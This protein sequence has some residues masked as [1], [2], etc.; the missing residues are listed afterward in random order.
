MKSFASLLPGGNP[1]SKESMTVLDCI[2][3]GQMFHILDALCWNRLSLLDY[4][5]SKTM[6]T[7]FLLNGVHAVLP[8]MTRSPP[9][10]DNPTWL[11]VGL[12]CLIVNIPGVECSLGKNKTVA[13]WNLVL[14]S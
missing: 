9:R 1:A 10:P 4:E 11:T 3:D 2:S 13:I 12:A 7:G 6:N 5:V 8:Y 14:V